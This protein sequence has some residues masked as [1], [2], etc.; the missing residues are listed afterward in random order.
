[1][2]HKEELETFFHKLRA[3]GFPYATGYLEE[4]VR[5]YVPKEYL[6]WHTKKADQPNAN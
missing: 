6:S 3:K 1:M 2:E 5:M 4:L